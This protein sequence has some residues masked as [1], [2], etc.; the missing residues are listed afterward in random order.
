MKKHYRYW[1][2]ELLKAALLE[3]VSSLNLD[4]NTINTLERAGIIK[5]ENLLDL[6]QEQLLDIKNVGPTK[7]KK[8]MNAL[9]KRGFS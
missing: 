7:Q 3:P 2:K 6:T 9:K 5:I 8:I 4:D 1:D